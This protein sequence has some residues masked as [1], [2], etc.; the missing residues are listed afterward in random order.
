[1]QKLIMNRESYMA[2]A[3]SSGRSINHLTFPIM[4]GSVVD[5]AIRGSAVYE[6]INQ[7][8]FFIIK[9]EY[10]FIS[11]FMTNNTNGLHA[12]KNKN[13]FVSSW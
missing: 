5:L 9:G 10:N 7:I 8:G 2:C 4:I 3:L 11:Y 6:N 12:Y 13:I 1:M